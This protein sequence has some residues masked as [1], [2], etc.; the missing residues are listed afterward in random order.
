MISP[1]IES[2]VWRIAGVVV[3]GEIVSG[4]FVGIGMSWNRNDFLRNQKEDRK[5][6]L[7]VKPSHLEL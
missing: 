3:S 6:E 1:L 4:L 2:C 5:S 7:S